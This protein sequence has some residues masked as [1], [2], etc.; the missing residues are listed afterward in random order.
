MTAIEADGCEEK[1]QKIQASQ[2]ATGI[3]PHNHFKKT[4][5]LGRRGRK[6]PSL[7][8]KRK[9]KQDRRKEHKTDWRQPRVVSIPLKASVRKK[10][11]AQ[12]GAKRGSVKGALREVNRGEV[13]KTA[14]MYGSPNESRGRP[15]NNGLAVDYK[16][17]IR[18]WKLER[19]GAVED[20]KKE[21]AIWACQG[22]RQS[23]TITAQD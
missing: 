17:K 12:Q 9:G 16:G 15:V 10:G 1:R 11:T 20:T 2:F 19:R 5:W 3:K 22:R 7:W 23:Y 6:G 21:T 4:R 14:T 8:R 13:R 18:A